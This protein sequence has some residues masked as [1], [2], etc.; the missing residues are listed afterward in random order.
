MGIKVKKIKV[1]KQILTLCMIDK[2]FSHFYFIF[3]HHHLP[4]KYQ[5]ILALHKLT[6]IGFKAFLKSQILAMG[7]NNVS[8]VSE[9]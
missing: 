4:F 2:N 9:L 5:N 6:F 7:P 1:M 3:C 8:L